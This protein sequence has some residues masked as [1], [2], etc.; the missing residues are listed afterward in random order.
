MFSDD[1][2]LTANC[3]PGTTTATTAGKGRTIAAACA[4][5]VALARRARASRL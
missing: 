1:M 4:A 3:A 5:V 2:N